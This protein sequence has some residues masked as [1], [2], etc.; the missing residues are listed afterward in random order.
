MIQFNRRALKRKSRDL[1][2]PEDRPYN[3][4]DMPK[5]R[6]QAHIPQQSSRKRRVVRRPGF[7]EAPQPEERVDLDGNPIFAETPAS[8]L[9]AISAS[10]ASGPVETRPHWIDSTAQQQRQPGRRVAQLRR[11][12]AQPAARVSVGQLPTFSAGYLSEELRRIA[13]TAGSLFALIIVL[14]I[15][16]R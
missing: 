3:S 16:M 4:I 1:F 2:G 6:R 9:G 14:A 7:A 8:P 13:I 11:G 10:G 12:P 5:K 15:V